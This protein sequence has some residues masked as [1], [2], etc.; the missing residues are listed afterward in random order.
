MLLISACGAGT[1]LGFRFGNA[2]SRVPNQ[3]AEWKDTADLFPASPHPLFPPGRLAQRQGQP[4][5]HRPPS[6]AGLRFPEQSGLTPS[7]GKF[8]LFS[9]L[10]RDLGVR[11]RNRFSGQMQDCI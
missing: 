3:P 2:A 7:E 4:H 5:L 10:E 8:L 11:G 1:S 6:S 9:R